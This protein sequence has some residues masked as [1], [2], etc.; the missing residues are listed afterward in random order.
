MRSVRQSQHVTRSARRATWHLVAV[1]ASL[2][3]AACGGDSGPPT[4]P[5]GAATGASDILA[6]DVSCPTSILIGEKGPCVAVARLRSGQTPVVF[7]ANWSSSRP[8]RGNGRRTGR[9]R[10]TISGA[11]SHLRVLP[12]A[13]RRRSGFCDGRGRATHQ[14]RGGARRIQI[15]NDRDDVVARLLLC[16]DGRKRSPAAADK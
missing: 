2:G 16:C 13:K 5:S 11:G 12:W 3:M 4:S 1:L 9:R 15:R 14:G 8:G 7:E 6:L 10:R